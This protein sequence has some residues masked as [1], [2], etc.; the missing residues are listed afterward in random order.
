MA[1]T[2][3]FKVYRNGE[4]IAACRYGEDAAALVAL[5]GDGTVRYGHRLV[6]WTE[7]QE[8]FPAGESYDGAAAIMEQRIETLREATRR[9]ATR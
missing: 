7:G 2:P 4:Y 6:V 1:Q 9:R 3:Q 8:S 5:T